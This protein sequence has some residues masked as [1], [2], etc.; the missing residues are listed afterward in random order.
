MMDTE[1]LLSFAKSAVDGSDVQ[2]DLSTNPATGHASISWELA[3]AERC[4][5]R[6]LPAKKV[7]KV[8]RGGKKEEE[9][10]ILHALMT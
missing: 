5:W 7:I 3:I 2:N 4:C 9:R 10:K 1:D 6:L 8:R